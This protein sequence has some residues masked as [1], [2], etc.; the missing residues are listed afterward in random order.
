M[1]LMIRVLSLGLMV[2]AALL[3]A[4]AEPSQYTIRVGVELVDVNFSV[5]DR[6]GRT[7]PDLT[8]A[9]FSVEED[10]KTQEILRF[11]RDELPLTL[12]LLIDTSPSVR[13][14]FGEEIETASAFVK[15]IMRPKDIA[16]VIT[17]DNHVTLMQD[18]TDSPKVLTAVIGDLR[19]RRQGTSLFDA[20]YLAASEKLAREFG[21]K[22]IILISD[23]EDTTSRYDLSKALI[24]A[25]RSNAVIYSISNRGGGSATLRKLSEETGGAVFSI[26]RDGEFKRVFDQIALELRSQYSLSYRSNNPKADGA[27][28]QIRIVPR[29]SNLVVRARRGYYAP[30]E[31]AAK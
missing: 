22:T 18:F 2:A 14:V 20:V 19:L 15:S 9:D 30:D 21:R 10:G 28:R 16:L 29:D 1:A 7:P 11:S 17:F 5:T 4:A 27:Y 26:R 6:K 24:A 13:P 31:P 12:A 8:A 3:T 23:G 25:H